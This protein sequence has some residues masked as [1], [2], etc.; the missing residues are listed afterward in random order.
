MIKS[1]NYY[2][3]ISML[4]LVVIGCFFWWSH[5]MM[6]HGNWW[7]GWV[8]VSLWILNWYSWTIAFIDT[9]FSSWWILYTANTDHDIEVRADETSNYTLSWDLTSPTTGNWN[10]NYT[11]TSWIT[12]QWPDWLKTITW[13][14]IN[15]TSELV[16]PS[17]LEIYLDTTP[18]SSPILYWPSAWSFAWWDSVLFEW[19]SST[20][21]SSWFKEYELVMSLSPTMSSPRSYTTTQTSLLINKELLP[22]WN[23]YRYVIACDNVWNQS[24]SLPSYIRQSIFGGSNWYRPE[25]WASSIRP[26]DIDLPEWVVIWDTLYEQTWE[27]A[28]TWL[29]YVFADDNDDSKQSILEIIKANNEFNIRYNKVSSSFH[30]AAGN[31][32]NTNNIVQSENYDGNLL[33]LPMYLSRTWA[34]V[35]E[36][37]YH[38][39]LISKYFPNEEVKVQLKKI[40]AALSPRQKLSITMILLVLC[41]DIETYK[42]W[43]KSLK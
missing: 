42:K 43:L 21:S 16:I 39:W 23:I 5:A 9:Y 32:E 20:D 3:S 24:I 37:Q 10:W 38:L 6:A 35:D 17:N 14:F 7:N 11:N 12:L 33:T 40:I 4:L 13:E 19:S 27:D 2:I 31:W 30:N 26:S 22:S 36:L 34:N 8:W 29:T 1:S 15:D 41:Y 28:E 25:P 18:P